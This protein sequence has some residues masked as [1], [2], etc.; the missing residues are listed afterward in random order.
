M[1]TLL[2]SSS[3]GDPTSDFTQFIN[4]LDL[5]GFRNPPF[6][7]RTLSN[8]S[9]FDSLSVSG[10]L[11]LALWREREGLDLFVASLYGTFAA[12]LVASSEQPIVSALASAPSC[13]PQSLFVTPNGRS[14]FFI[15]NES[16]WMFDL[17]Q[18][19]RERDRENVFSNPLPFFFFSCRLHLRLR[20][21]CFLM[22][23]LCM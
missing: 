8:Q 1:N 17:T 18:V 19:K 22:C 15:A 7:L 2:F 10:S 5:Q 14:A 11:N 13:C 20:R 21:C 4:S 3:R 16:L 23:L 6:V 9:T 12:R